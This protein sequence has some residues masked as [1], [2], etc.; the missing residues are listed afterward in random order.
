[1]LIAM[2]TYHTKHQNGRPAL[3][4]AVERGHVDVMKVLIEKVAD[5]NTQDDVIMYRSLLHQSH[6][7]SEH[8]VTYL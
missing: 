7:C 1:M 3:S 4:L 2:M 8:V 6:A 5:V